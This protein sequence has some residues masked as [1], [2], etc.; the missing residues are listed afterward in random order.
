MRLRRSPVL[1]WTA[2]GA[3]ALF[4]GLTVSGLAG[5][6]AARAAALGGLEEVAV[7]ARPVAAG[8]VLTAADV[9]VR[10]LPA[11]LLPDS[12]PARAPRGRVALV[13]LAEGEVLLASRLAPEGAD[14]LAA[15]LPEGMRALAVPV[16]TAAP[17]LRRGHRVDV[18]ATFDTVEPAAEPTIAVATGALVIDV[19]EDAVT[20]AV[21]PSEAPRLAFA[22]ARGIVTLALTPSSE[23]RREQGR[24]PVIGGSSSE[25]R[26]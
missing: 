2:A 12:P 20:L 16:D 1:F 23:L 13:D 26:P 22:M 8:E 5:R 6:A 7:A 24:F 11:A 18:L 4:T 21:S 14:G 25:P 10:S 3:V 17:A 15:L 9:A 19:D